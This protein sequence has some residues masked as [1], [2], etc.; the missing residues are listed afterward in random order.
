MTNLV[1]HL[2]R[3]ASGPTQF[4]TLSTVG[5]SYAAST[6]TPPRRRRSWPFWLVTTS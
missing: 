2:A 6:F 4:S 3:E 1:G 5:P